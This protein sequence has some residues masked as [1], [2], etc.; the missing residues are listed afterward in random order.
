VQQ[1][2]HLPQI[3]RLQQLV[4]LLL[5]VP[6]QCRLLV[7]HLVLVVNR[8]QQHFIVLR[9]GLNTMLELLLRKGKQQFVHVV[10]AVLQIRHGNNKSIAR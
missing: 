1:P 3:L 5:Q 8:L 9:E 6:D 10:D 2:R 4:V 7:Y